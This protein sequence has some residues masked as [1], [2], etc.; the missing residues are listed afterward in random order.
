M[1]LKNDRYTY[2]VTW[3][4]E[5]GE[6]VGLCAEFPSLSWLARTPED[7]LKGIRNVVAEVVRDMK[8]SGDQVP[9]PLAS[10]RFSGRFMVRVPPSV[11]RR[12][13]VEAAESG[14]SLNRLASAKLAG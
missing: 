2:R 13:A 3:S 9:E 1:T 12:L 6:H 8:A 10:R 7:A 14:I 4:E 5:D 11:H